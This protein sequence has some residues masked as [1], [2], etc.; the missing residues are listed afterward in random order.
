MNKYADFA[1]ST[2]KKLLVS[3]L[4][5][6]MNGLVLPSSILSMKAA[7]HTLDLIWTTEC[8]REVPTDV[9]PGLAASRLDPVGLNQPKANLCFPTARSP[10]NADV[11]V[12]AKYLNC[13]IR[14]PWSFKKS[15]NFAWIKQHRFCFG[16]D[17]NNEESQFL[18]PVFLIEDICLSQ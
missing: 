16:T 4:L 18:S 2:E 14:Q 10:P 15:R 17:G 1:T 11:K 9:G 13:L 12:C 6:L 3:S 7:L 8:G 5:N